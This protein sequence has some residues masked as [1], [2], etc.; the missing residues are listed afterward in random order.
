MIA[1]HVISGFDPPWIDQDFDRNLKNW[2]ETIDREAL[3]EYT[4][5]M[6]LPLLSRALLK[7]FYA[8]YYPALLSGM[9]Y[10]R[11]LSALQ[12][13]PPAQAPEPEPPA[14]KIFQRRGPKKPL[15]LSAPDEPGQ[16]RKGR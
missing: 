8:I 5:E 13:L 11:I 14:P 9:E 1:T 6:L 12:K 7:M 15:T 10:T 3:A 4:Q 16:F 2:L